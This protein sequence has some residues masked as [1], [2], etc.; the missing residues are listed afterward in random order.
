M[1]V[2]GLTIFTTERYQID[3]TRTLWNV[4]YQTIT[5]VNKPGVYCSGKVTLLATAQQ[6]FAYPT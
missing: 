6:K 3:A 4:D 2:I 1:L 5:V